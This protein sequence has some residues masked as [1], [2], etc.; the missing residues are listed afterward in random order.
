MDTIVSSSESIDKA[1]DRYLD[2]A[3]LWKDQDLEDQ[4]DAI[5]ALQ[6]SLGI[7]GDVRVLLYERVNEM[8]TNV[9]RD[10]KAWLL[11]GVILGLMT[12]EYESGISA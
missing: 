3:M 8:P 12:A 7:N 10:P 5:H 6:E 11:L 9:F 1:F 2:F 4:L